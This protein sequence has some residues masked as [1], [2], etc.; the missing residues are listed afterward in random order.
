[1]RA[2]KLICSAPTWRWEERMPKRQK[3]QEVKGRV[4]VVPRIV[5][6]RELRVEIIG[7]PEGLAILGQMFTDLAHGDQQAYNIP[8]GERRHFHLEYSGILAGPSAR[9]EL[10]RADAS[11][12]GELPLGIVGWV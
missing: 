2:A 4:W 5:N 9:T 12:T 1:M 3:D 10:I 7:N 11:G 6:N 8:P